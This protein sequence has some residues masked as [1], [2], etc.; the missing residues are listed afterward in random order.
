MAPSEEDE[1]SG[2]TLVLLEGSGGKK[3]PS[4]V[5][6]EVSGWGEVSGCTLVLLEEGSG[7]KKVTPSVVGEVS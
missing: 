7:G 2:C 3:V 5:V 6:G 4:S 1:V